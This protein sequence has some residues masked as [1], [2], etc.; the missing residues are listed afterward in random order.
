LPKKDDGFFQEIENKD[1]EV[2]GCCL[3]YG[4]LYATA[5]LDL[6]VYYVLIKGISPSLKKL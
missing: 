3:V 4:L 5:L 6:F 2:Q 1:E